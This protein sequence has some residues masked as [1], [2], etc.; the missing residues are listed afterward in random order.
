M[1]LHRFHCENAVLMQL[2]AALS[3]SPCLS[4]E[5]NGLQFLCDR[6][7]ET[8]MLFIEGLEDPLWLLEQPYTHTTN[9]TVL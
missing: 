9:K 6:N 3:G 5:A 1:L 7:D 4:A 2:C 8:Q